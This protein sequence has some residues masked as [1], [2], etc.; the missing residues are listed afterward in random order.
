MRKSKFMIVL[1]FLAAG[2]WSFAKDV[3][4]FSVGDSPTLD[5]INI[6]GNIAIKAGTAGAITVEYDREDDRVEVII[7]AT[8]DTVTVRTEYPKEV[9]NFRGGVNFEITV[10][11]SGKL[12]VESVSGSITVNGV[13]G[14]LM[15]QS[16]S[17]DVSVSQSAGDLTLSSTSGD[18]AL[19]AIGGARIDASVISGSV[20]YKNGD[21]AGGPYKFSSVS[22]N[23]RVSHGPNASYKISGNTVS[24][25]IKNNVG[26]E[27]T[28]K[29]PKY[30][31]SQS[32]SGD[33][34]GGEAS[35]SI[36]SVSGSVAI[37]LE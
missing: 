21:L 13:E 27:L 33:F 12:K 3:Q 19:D 32:L 30:G 10:P 23:V 35:V 11:A 15:L 20:T 28:V 34:N 17:G 7:E 5:L 4:E 22:G 37:T 31:P 8:G 16:V 26:D 14:E 24:G 9:R 29:K 25:S 36:N 1:I 2:A 6:S 18:V